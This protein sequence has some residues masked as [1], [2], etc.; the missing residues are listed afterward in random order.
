MFHITTHHAPLGSVH[1][2]MNHGGLCPQG[3]S[4]LMRETKPRWLVDALDEGP[5]E[6]TH[7]SLPDA[8]PS[9]HKGLRKRVELRALVAK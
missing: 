1:P 7:E 8:H 4:F 9:S 3:V 5:A 2:E 6:R